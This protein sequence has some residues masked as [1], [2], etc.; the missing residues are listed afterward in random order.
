MWNV[1]SES[2]TSNNI[3][4]WNYLYFIQKI[5]DQQTG[6]GRN[7]GNTVSSHIGHYTHT[8][9]HTHTHTLRKC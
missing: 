5:P 1:Q 2:E 4:N 8:H 3:G 7:Q 6:T 9:T